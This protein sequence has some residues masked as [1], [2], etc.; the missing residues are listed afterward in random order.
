MAK[1][2]SNTSENSSASQS[3][4]LGMF[5]P[6]PTAEII[7]AAET[8]RIR[9][10]RE[11][12]EKADKKAADVVVALIRAIG[13][14]EYTDACLEKINAAKQAYIQLTPDQKLL[15]ENADVITTSDKNS[16]TID[17]PIIPIP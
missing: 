7:N 10:E 3:A 17:L 13:V 6:I 8:A 2:Q 1:K 4:K 16:G 9:A 5:I 11:A 12:K 14:V 15:V